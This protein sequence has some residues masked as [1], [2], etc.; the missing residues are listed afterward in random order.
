M[1]AHAEGPDEDQSGVSRRSGRRLPLTSEVSRAGEEEGTATGSRGHSTGAGHPPRAYHKA[2]RAAMK[3]H[4]DAYLHYLALEKN[5]SPNTIA[6]Y[7]LDLDRYLGFLEREGVASPGKVTEKHAHRFLRSLSSAGLAPR[8]VTRTVSAIKGFHKFLLADG[9]TRTDPTG[10]IESPKLSR[11]LPDVLSPTE[12]DSILHQPV[13]DAQD[14]RQL[15]IRDKAILEVLY[16]TGIRVSE[17]ITLKQQNIHA[18]PGII[19]VFGK[20]SKERLV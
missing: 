4:R 12:I 5:A 2:N 16:A 17:L 19:R 3:R 15:W 11:S 14:R 13:P 6:S 9:I 7:G 8:S 18:N 10:A 1:S 20:G